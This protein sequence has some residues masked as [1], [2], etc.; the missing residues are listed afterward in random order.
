M[1]VGLR[2]DGVLR[3]GGARRATR[4]HA[5]LPRAHGPTPPS[6]APRNRNRRAALARAR[7]HRARVHERQLQRREGA[8][9]SRRDEIMSGIRRWLLAKHPS[10][11][12]RGIGDDEDLVDT[13]ILSSLELV[14]FLLFLEDERGAPILVERLD[15][16]SIRTLNRI[17]RSFFA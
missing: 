2:A 5:L 8:Q 11:S 1:D 14:E 7:C 4:R 17:Y 10:L 3:R 9:M 16:E 13:G 12:E 6:A 15:P